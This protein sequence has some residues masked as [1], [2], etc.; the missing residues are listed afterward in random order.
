MRP[1]PRAAS[2][3]AL[4][5]LL[6]GAGAVPPPP[7]GAPPAAPPPP[8]LADRAA[9]IESV[10]GAPDGERVVLGHLSR[11]LGMPADALRAQRTRT[12]LGWGD[13]LIANRLAVETQAPLDDLIAEFRGGR[14]W[15]SIAREH[16]ADLERLVS[17]MRSSEEAVEQHSEDKSPHANSPAAPGGRSRGG[18]AGRGRRGY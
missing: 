16:G 1:M 6:L 14:V 17:D 10:A 8:T 3:M 5:C 9:A 18:S 4:A 7:A 12:G 2:I 13:L 11:K 15:E